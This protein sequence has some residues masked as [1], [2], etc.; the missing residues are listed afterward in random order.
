M[1]VVHQHIHGRFERTQRALL[2]KHPREHALA[3]HHQRTAARVELGMLIAH[4]LCGPTNRLI[5]LAVGVDELLQRPIKRAR[6]SGVHHLD[7]ELVG[8]LRIRGSRAVALEE[9]VVKHPMHALETRFHAEIGA[10]A[11]QT[12]HGERIAIRQC[13]IAGRKL[14]GHTRHAFDILR[15]ALI[16][17]V[18]L[19][20]HAREGV[21]VHLGGIGRNMRNASGGETGGHALRKQGKVCQR[22]EPAVALAERDPTRAAELA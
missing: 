3:G 2:L 6:G 15:I 1:R 10:Q 22:Q 17:L 21:A 14:V 11:L 12:F 18:G 9:G 5:Q 16:E 8:Q 13:D 19:G 4:A 20:D 7:K